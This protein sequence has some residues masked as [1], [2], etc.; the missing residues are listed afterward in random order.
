MARKAASKSARLTEP[1]P[2]F[3]SCAMNSANRPSATASR[4]DNCDLSMGENVSDLHPLVIIHW[5]DSRQPSSSWRFISDL[6][7]QNPVEC[8]SVGWLI[9][10][11]EETKAICQNVGDVNDPDNAQASGVMVIPARCI[12]SIAELSET[13]SSVPSSHPVRERRPPVS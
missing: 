9:Q 7:D 1:T 13:T 6:K 10:D 8:I 4:K 3:S 5:Q 12:I 11:D 2:R